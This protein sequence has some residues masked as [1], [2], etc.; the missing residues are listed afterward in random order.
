MNMT[1]KACGLT[2]PAATLLLQWQREDGGA[3]LKVRGRGGRKGG[4]GEDCG[5][6]ERLGRDDEDTMQEREMRAVGEANKDF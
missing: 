2:A 3:V 5:G 6:Q 4:R 1:L